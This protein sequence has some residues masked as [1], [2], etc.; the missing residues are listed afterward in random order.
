MPFPVPGVNA[1]SDLEGFF[2]F[3]SSASSGSFFPIMILVF[4]IIAFIGSLASGKEASKG[5]IFA[6]FIGIVIALPLSILGWVNI[7]YV[8][9][10]ILVLGLTTI[11]IFLQQQRNI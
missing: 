4:W 3:V 2:G 10:Q 1:T 11:W 9:L 5:I 7:T 8:Y 6:C